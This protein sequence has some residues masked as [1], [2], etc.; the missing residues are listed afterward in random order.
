MC[1]SPLGLEVSSDLNM[2]ELVG[3]DIK[4]VNSVQDLVVLIQT[5][6]EVELVLEK[7]HRIIHADR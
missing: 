3:G 5:T 1:L 2:I 4:L 6:V 7:S